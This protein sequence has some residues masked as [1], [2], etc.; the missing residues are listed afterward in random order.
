M[1]KKVFQKINSEIE[2]GEVG[3]VDFAEAEGV[4]D[5]AFVSFDFDEVFAVLPAIIEGEADGVFIVVGF[6]LPFAA[7]GITGV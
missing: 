6:E 5:E 3:F 7:V 2:G 1:T 4:G